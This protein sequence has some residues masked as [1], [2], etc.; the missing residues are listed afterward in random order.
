MSDSTYANQPMSRLA[1]SGMVLLSL[2]ANAV[3][4]LSMFWM[5]GFIWNLPQSP[6][7]ITTSASQSVLF[8]LLT[9]SALILLFGIQH[10]VMAR[11]SVKAW[12][13]RFINP[14]AIRSVY[15][16]ASS[17]VLMLIFRFWQPLPGQLW[18]LTATPLAYLIY[19]LGA[20]GLGIVIWA[21]G[22]IDA[23]DFLGVSDAIAAVTGEAKK[24]AEFKTPLPYRIVRHPMQLGAMLFLWA[25]PLMSAS[26]LMFAAAMTLY[27][28]IG[29][30][31]EECALMREF[32]ETYR[33]Y[34]Q[35]VPAVIPRLY[36][37]R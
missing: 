30:Y 31:F 12:L 21:M 27:I 3:Y 4:N 33:D 11:A 10:S 35:K 16:I 37:R 24:P 1:G 9:N 25:T 22:S 14:L 32:S 29:L 34:K 5:V 7:I 6:T 8:A 15:I 23:M 36:R 20:L 26:H 17:I 19:G 13:S 2:S 28:V 18:D